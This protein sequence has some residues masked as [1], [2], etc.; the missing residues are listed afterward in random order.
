V[1]HTPGTIGYIS[2]AAAHEGVKE[3][4]VH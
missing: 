4:A 2:K 3:L 1:A